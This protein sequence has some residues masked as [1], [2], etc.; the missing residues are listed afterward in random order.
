MA[1]ERAP[2]P[3]AHRAGLVL[4]QLLLGAGVVLAV[5]L[6]ARTLLQRA[7]MRRLPEGYAIVRP[8]QEVSALALQGDVVWAGGAGG[9][10]AIDRREPRLLP[11]PPGAPNLRRVRDLLVDAEDRLWIAHRGGLT[12]LHE[13]NWR[14]WTAEIG[15]AH[16]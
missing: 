16:V 14:T 15:R 1:E 10:Y 4:L 3:R 8:P 11:L 12:A 7:A 2:R 13:G 6:G 9:L 5:G